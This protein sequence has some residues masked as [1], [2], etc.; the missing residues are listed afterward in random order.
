AMD[1]RTLRIGVLLAAHVIFLSAAALRIIRGQRRH[2]L[3]SRAAW[4]LQY[5]PPLV[6]IPF[7][8]A[9]VLPLSIE[10]AYGLQLAGVVL[11]VGSALFA[12][13]AMWSLGRSYGIRMDLFEGHRLVTEGPYRVVRHPMYL[14]ILSFHIGAIFA[15]QSLLLLA[16]T[17][18]YV[19]PFTA[20]RIVAEERVLLQ[21]FGDAYGAFVR[22][23]PALVP[24]AR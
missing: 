14:G 22:R 10:L 13:W 2:L 1:D 11:A 15:L 18:L 23:V 3:R 20:V 7:V 4:W 16:A 19:V 12:A 24:F 17:A 21:G 8:V 6:W 9:Y 5:Y